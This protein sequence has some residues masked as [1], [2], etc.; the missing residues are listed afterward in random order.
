MQFFTLILISFLEIAI[1]LKLTKLDLSQ[2]SLNSTSNFSNFVNKAIKTTNVYGYKML[3]S[4]IKEPPF[5]ISR[6]DQILL[7]EGKRL[8]SFDDFTVRL[9]TFFTMGMYQ[10]NMFDA[11]DNEKLIDS[12]KM[13][14]LEIIPDIL[15]GT[16][17]CIDIEDKIFGKRF[18]MCLKLEILEEIR[19]SFLDFFICNEKNPCDTVMKANMKVTTSIFDGVQQE[20]KYDIADYSI[21]TENN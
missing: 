12:I 3:D 21:I 13:S 6:C 16:Q 1:S 14:N 20:K 2:L 15:H 19:R 18:T 8:K 10:I 11:E 9:S 5:K 17:N 4:H 7:F